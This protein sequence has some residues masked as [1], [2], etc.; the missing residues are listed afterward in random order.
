[1]I[2]KINSD[3]RDWTY[4]HYVANSLRYLAK[5]EGEYLLPTLYEALHP[6]PVDN[7]TGDE[8]AIDVIKKA[9]LKFKE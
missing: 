2:A 7:R 4:R 6:K 3:I 5:G 9:G 8:I 1:M